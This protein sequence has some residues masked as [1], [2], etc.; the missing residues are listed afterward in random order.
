MLMNKLK[1]DKKAHITAVAVETIR[2]YGARKTTIEDISLASGMAPATLYYYFRSKSDLVRAAMDTLLNKSFH[3]I[4]LIINSRSTVEEKLSAAMKSVLLRFSNSG[5]IMDMNK[6]ARSTMLAMANEFADKFTRRYKALIKSILS[7]GNRTE[8]FYVK[9]IDLTASVLS[10]AVF[11]YIINAVEV[12][13]AELSETLVDNVW[14]LLI[15]GL[16]KR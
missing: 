3:D 9:N 11:G 6:S 5:I 7:E 1:D 4:D 2:K 8:V 15:Y 14:E 12:E 10:S 16:K 13:S